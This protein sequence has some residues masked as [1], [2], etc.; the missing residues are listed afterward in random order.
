M[1]CFDKTYCKKAFSRLYLA[2]NCFFKKILLDD[3]LELMDLF[4][5][6]SARLLL[7]EVKGLF[8]NPELQDEV[9]NSEAHSACFRIAL[10]CSAENAS[11]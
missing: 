3:L 10:M 11:S 8:K 6:K 2:K 5:L 1:N 4:Q 7:Q 9:R